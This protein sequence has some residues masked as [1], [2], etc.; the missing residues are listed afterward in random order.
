MGVHAQIVERLLLMTIRA[1]PAQGALVGIVVT[2]SA[3][4]LQT[5]VAQG[6][7]RQDF[8]VGVLVTARA[9]QVEMLSPHREANAVV[10][11]G[12]NIRYAR[13]RE[14][15]GI[16][17]AEVSPMVFG[18][19]KGAAPL[20]SPRKKPVQAAFVFQLPS[21]RLMAIEAG[22]RHV[23]PPT[24]VAGLATLPSIKLSHSIMHPG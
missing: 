20:V 13:Q 11:K 14:R 16:D 4:L 17:H 12:L 19:A 21:D 22:C 1:A 8:V 9:V 7:F 24:T 5:E 2:C 23:R 6:A 10:I 15:Q 3:R 18:M